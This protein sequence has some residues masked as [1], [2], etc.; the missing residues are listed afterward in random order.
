MRKL[1]LFCSI[2][3]LFAYGC[4]KY[5]PTDTNCSSPPCQTATGE[6]CPGNLVYVNGVCTCLDNQ[7]LIGNNLCANSPENFAVPDSINPLDTDFKVYGVDLSCGCLQNEGVLLGVSVNDNALVTGGIVSY[8]TQYSTGSGTSLNAHS[9]YL[10]TLNNK[11]SIYD[12]EA[13]LY[14]VCPDLY[15]IDKPLIIN[16]SIINDTLYYD[17]YFLYTTDT[18]KGF[19]TSRYN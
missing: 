4:C 17:L 3:G 1:I 6:Y 9:K 15:G 2:V 5:E 13:S 7:T 12:F 14:K 18:C 10:V 8:Y 11:D 19:K 16:G